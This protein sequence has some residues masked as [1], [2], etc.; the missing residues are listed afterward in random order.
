MKLLYLL[1]SI[2]G[3]KLSAMRT[4]VSTGAV[5]NGFIV[6]LKFF[7]EENELLFLVV[8]QSLYGKER[9]VLRKYQQLL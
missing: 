3:D 6:Q 8:V 1:S 5:L 9:Q 2:V 7:T 4:L